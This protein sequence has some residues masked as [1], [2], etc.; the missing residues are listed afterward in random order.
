MVAPLLVTLREGLEA[1][2]I[3]GIIVAYLVRTGNRDGLR[4]VW[5]GTGLAVL[6]SL[7]AGAGVFFT[8]GALEGAAEQV[9]EGVAMLVAV[10]MLSYVVVWMR[11]QSSGLR[12]QLQEKLQAAVGS[13]SGLALL[14]MAFVVVVR[15]GIETALFFF[16]ATRAA[17]PTESVVGGLLGL[18]LAVAL[19][20]SIYRGSHRLDLRAFFN[21]TG[22]LLILF[23]AG[24]LAHGIHEFH[25]AGL[26]PEVVAHV[27]DV[28][29]LID[30]KSTPGRFLTALVGYNGNPSLVEVVAYLAYLAAAL[31]YYF[32]SA[33]RP[34]AVA[35]PRSRRIA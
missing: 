30:E 7:L 25:E 31:A 18:V 8:V 2:L 9:F 29:W 24:L 16:A 3:L 22:L 27:W 35:D 14:L 11:H 23:A 33:G 21:V 5:L 17:T 34:S 13:G 28:N 10:A 15:E 1:A 26:I 4:P 32:R 12:A 20:Y 6:A 19:G